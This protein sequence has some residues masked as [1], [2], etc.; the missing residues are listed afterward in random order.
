MKKS[1]PFCAIFASFIAA[2]LV[3]APA[4]FAGDA[5]Y[6]H[7]N[8]QSA[9]NQ[10]T[11]LWTIP[12]ISKRWGKPYRSSHWTIPRSAAVLLPPDKND[13]SSRAHNGTKQH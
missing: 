10:D 9:D 3:L 7:P 11:R 1:Q 8:S 6:V 5:V 4:A 13:H 2:L 12:P